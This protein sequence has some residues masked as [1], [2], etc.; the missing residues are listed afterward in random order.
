MYDTNAPVSL[1]SFVK[2][3]AI[4]IISTKDFEASICIIVECKIYD[5]SI[6]LKDPLKYSK[7]MQYNII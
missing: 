1:H 5:R 6:T 7:I 2:P 4:N 3:F